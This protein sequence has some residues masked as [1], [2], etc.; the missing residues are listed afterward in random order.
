[1]SGAVPD[2]PDFFL[3]GAMESAT[4]SLFRYVVQHPEVFEQADKEP[5]HFASP[6]RAPRYTGPG[7]D[8]TSSP[9]NRGCST[10]TARVYHR[11]T[12]PARGWLQHDLPPAARGHPIASATPSPTPGSSSCCA[13]PSP[14]PTRRGGCGGR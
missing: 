7:D 9:A 6:D 1:M 5:G 8:G 14:A 4:T 2:L 13:T 10:T 11:P 12:G 3:V